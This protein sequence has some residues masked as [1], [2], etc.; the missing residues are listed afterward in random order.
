MATITPNRARSLAED[1]QRVRGPLDRL[2]GYI[3]TYV[4]LEGLALALLFLAV[5]F[6]VGFLIDYGF[7]WLFRLDWIDYL[8]RW[9]RGGVLSLGFAVLAIMVATVVLFRLLR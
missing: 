4:S 8:P 3:R 1:N 9:F 2:R 7:F 5:C 6:W